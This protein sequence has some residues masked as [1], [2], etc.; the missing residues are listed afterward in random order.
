MIT[1]KPTN[2]K[3]TGRKLSISIGLI[4]ASVVYA[5]YQNTIPVSSVT[6]FRNN[7][8]QNIP[9]Q[10]ALQ[11]QPIPSTLPKKSPSVTKTPTTTTTPP[12]IPPPTQPPTPVKN[13]TGQYTDGTYTGSPADAYYGTIQVQAI[14]Q[15]GVLAD[16]QFLQYPN[17]RN[18]S[19]RVN[20][21][22]LPILRQ[23]AISAQNANVN[24]VSG[25]T[26]SSQAFQQ[27]LASALSQA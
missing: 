18:T 26:D 6:T 24:I 8:I 27:S 20:S 11:T 5:F 13:P 14:I 3:K 17:D 4:L 25:A 10:I 12:P 1:T 16:V 21:R 22:A 15:N 7:S 23:E 9:L 2:N 19:I